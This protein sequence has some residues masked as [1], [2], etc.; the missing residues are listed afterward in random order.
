MKNK[1]SYTVVSE[2]LN[3]YK[4]YIKNHHR[5]TFTWI[6]IIIILVLLAICCIVGPTL[7]FIFFKNSCISSI[8]YT[9]VTLGL[10]SFSLFENA[11]ISSI[12]KVDLNIYKNYC[13]EMYK[14]FSLIQK[15]DAQY[16]KN[17]INRARSDLD[18]KMVQ[19][20]EIRAEKT[21]LFCVVVIGTIIAI[22]SQLLGNSPSAG[23]CVLT[24]LGTIFCCQV[25]LLMK[26]FYSLL[27]DFIEHREIRLLHSF[28]TDLQYI[29]DTRFSYFGTL[30]ENS[31]S[32]KA[33]I[34]IKSKK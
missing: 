17:I 2:W 14:S 18:R 32:S 4:I 34:K 5:P 24:F 19:F 23:K 13:D 33:Y 9:I 8:Y 22:A 1:G 15:K 28:V 25:F 3:E 16:I 27:M 12:K 7:M 6:P 29:V 21:N 11:I 26:D 10:T 30:K 20:K 31:C